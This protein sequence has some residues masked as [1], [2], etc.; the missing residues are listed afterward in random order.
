MR[1]DKKFTL[2]KKIKFVY[3]YKYNILQYYTQNHEL[4]K[5][6]KIM[7]IEL[8]TISLKFSSRLALF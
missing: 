4:Q 7:K 6:Q 1:N 2:L 5:I 3:I 8:I